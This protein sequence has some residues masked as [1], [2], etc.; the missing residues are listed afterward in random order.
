MKAVFLDKDGT[1][2]EDV[3][4]NV[5]P[6]QIRLLPGVLE[7]LAA[8]HAAGY[9][10]VVVSNQS[11]VA[12]GYFEEK[13][14]GP[15]A[16]HLETLL[17]QAG[18][19]LAGFYYCPHYPEGTVAAYS[20]DCTCRKP[21][22]GL[23]RL[24]AQELGLELSRSW[25]VGDILNDIEAGHRAGCRAILLD[26]GNETKWVMSPLRRPEYVAQS[27]LEAAR[28]VVQ[29]EGGSAGFDAE[30]AGYPGSGGLW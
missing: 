23:L 19:P 20:F 5:N 24:A 4:Y 22:P 18:I 28:L 26:N 14:L 2:I 10:L 6:A 8:L 17:D 25:M 15:V 11:G 7:G 16:Q 9:R 21:R 27:M 13:A 1:L 30:Q 12:K 3:P 29:A